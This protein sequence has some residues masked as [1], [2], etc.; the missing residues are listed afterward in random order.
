MR[1]ENSCIHARAMRMDELYSDVIGTEEMAIAYLRGQGIFSTSMQCPACDRWMI[2]DPI[3]R[4]WRCYRARCRKEIVLRDENL[5]FTFME[6]SGK[7]HSGLPLR[8]ILKL[9]WIFL[10][11]HMTN[12]NSV[13][14]SK[15]AIQTVVDWNNL[16]REVCSHSLEAEPKMVG[17]I[18]NPIQIDESFFSGRRKYNRGR[19]LQGN[20]AQPETENPDA[21]DWGD[22]D[23]VN[24]DGT[25]NAI[26]GADD[27][28]WAWVLGIYSNKN[29]VRFLRVRDRTMETLTE[30]IEK[31]VESGSVIVTDMWGG[32]NGLTARGF[33]HKKVNHSE[34]YVDPNTGAHTQGIERAWRTAK[35]YLRTEMGNRTLFQSHLDKAA[36]MMKHGED[37]E[38]LMPTFLDDVRTFYGDNLH[39]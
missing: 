4:R 24:D 30:V 39:R 38:N 32:Y 16:M 12:R 6:T 8:Q 7:L 28:S 9:L 19:L 34:N 1:S 15:C 17:T 26:Y 10:Y 21:Q 33:V 27:P 2:Y 3:R 22:E 36:W 29:E 23:P 11:T 13:Y 37:L 14:A 35:L 20:R 18:E 31:Y 5:F 25:Q